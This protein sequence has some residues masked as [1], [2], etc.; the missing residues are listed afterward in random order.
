MLLYHFRDSTVSFMWQNK[1]Q[2]TQVLL[3][4]CIV[5]QCVLIHFDSVLVERLPQF[6]AHRESQYEILHGRTCQ[7]ILTMNTR[8]FITQ[9][10]SIQ[11]FLLIADST[12][13]SYD[14]ANRPLQSP[15]PLESYA[16]NESIKLPAAILMNRPHS[17]HVYI[18]PRN[19]L[20]NSF[21]SPAIL[22]LVSMMDNSL[23]IGCFS[24]GSNIQ[25]LKHHYMP[26]KFYFVI[27]TMS[28]P[29]RS[30]CVKRSNFV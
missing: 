19:R 23:I 6:F 28:L 11:A 29:K 25:R 26:K 1:N 5:L 20:V 22:L 30:N 21:F 16:Q 12:F 10:Y 27:T 14:W 7:Y 18:N 15:F 4:E 2:L 13:P 9:R 24:C 8:T 3:S 17:S